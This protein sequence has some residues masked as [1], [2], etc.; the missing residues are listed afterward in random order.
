[1][2][3]ELNFPNYSEK[4]LE[5]IVENAPGKPFFDQY[6]DNRKQIGTVISASRVDSS[7]TISFEVALA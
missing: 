7:N 3:F 4:A 2:K 1:M 6:G 5:Q